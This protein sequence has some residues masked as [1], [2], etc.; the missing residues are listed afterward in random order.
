MA[1]PRFTPGPWKYETEDIGDEDFIVVPYTVTA[2]NGVQVIDSEGGLYSWEG[3]KT[4]PG[5][6]EAN[7]NLICAAPDLY[8]ACAGLIRVLDGPVG[9][10]D[11]EIN[12]EIAK[13]KAALAKVRG[14]VDR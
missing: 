11:D 10:N 8:A 6:R 7:A 4:R 5:E 3:A 13:A 1:E 9:P 2:A 14:E 12:A